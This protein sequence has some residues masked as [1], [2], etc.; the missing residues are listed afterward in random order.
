MLYYCQALI[1]IV[2]CAGCGIASFL[3]NDDSAH[4]YMHHWAQMFSN[5]REGIGIILIM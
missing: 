2:I 4:F 1:Y 3:T 5:D